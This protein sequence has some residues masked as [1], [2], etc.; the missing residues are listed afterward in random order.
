[1]RV[2]FTLLYKIN[3]S[4]WDGTNWSFNDVRAAQALTSCCSD[5]CKTFSSYTLLSVVCDGVEVISQLWSQNSL[6]FSSQFRRNTHE[7]LKGRNNRA[8]KYPAGLKRRNS[9][10]SVELAECK[11]FT[12]WMFKAAFTLKVKSC[13]QNCVFLA[14]LAVVELLTVT[15]QLPVMTQRHRYCCDQLQL[16]SLIVPPT[17]L[18]P[19]PPTS[20]AQSL[21][22]GIAPVVFFNLIT[23]NKKQISHSSLQSPDVPPQDVCPE[24]EK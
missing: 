3:R 7:R 10:P 1:M 6:H 22:A 13:N 16:F 12:Y 4:S 21:T 5:N 19:I 11:H 8:M 17:S 18:P 20:T 9:N 15:W 14:I 2:F 24:K 23:S